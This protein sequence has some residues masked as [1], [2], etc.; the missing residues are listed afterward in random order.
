MPS[1][2]GVDLGG[3]KCAVRRYDAKTLEEEAFEQIPTQ[4]EKGFDDVFRR[5]VGLIQQLSTKGTQSIGIG[6][7]GFVTYP[8]GTVLTLPNIDGVHNI[9]LKEKLTKI[10]HL[11]V[12][13]DNDVHCTALAEAHYGAGKGLS[14][15]VVV[16][17]GTGV[18]GGIVID[19]KLLRGSHGFAGEVGRMLLVP[20]QPP[21]ETNDKRGD[22]EQFLSGTSLKKR[23]PEAKNPQEYLMGETC[24]AIHDSV[25]R[26][27]AWL[28][29]SLTH[30]LDP[31]IIIFAGSAGR[32]LEPYLKDIYSELTHWV[33]PGTPIPK[34]AIAERKDAA[35]LGAALLTM[36]PMKN[37][38][39]SW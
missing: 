34:L 37:T 23:C 22:V 18:G 4:A 36:E 39:A 31:S 30:L 27:T 2:I 7:P 17:A 6:V 28:C 16:A 9:P 11:P 29:A 8:E 13:V 38:N 32:P 14:V 19:G 15:V 3:T 5:C 12:F 35:T 33:L 26:E 25:V 1:V 20:G 24:S 21:Y 10:L